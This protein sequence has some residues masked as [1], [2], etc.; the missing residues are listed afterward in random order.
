M[1]P[2]GFCQ[3]ICTYHDRAPL[4]QTRREEVCEHRSLQR[5]KRAVNG[6]PSRGGGCNVGGAAAH[7]AGGK[8]F[9]HSKRM[10]SL[11]LH[12][13]PL[14]PLWLPIY[15]F[16]PFTSFGATSGA[17]TGKGKEAREGRS[18]HQGCQHR[19]IVCYRQSNGEGVLCN[20]ERT[21][22]RRSDQHQG[23][24]QT[25]MQAAQYWLTTVLCQVHFDSRVQQLLLSSALGRM[26][27]C[28]AQRLVYLQV[29]CFTKIAD[30]GC[31]DHPVHVI[32]LVPI[33]KSS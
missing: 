14:A 6:L 11:S 29:I 15:P 20:P 23:T 31:G 5:R 9:K 26:A 17:A 3:S 21:G 7:R 1:G 16:L 12:A 18:G 27:N 33:K 30:Q 10:L 25:A 28:L 4:F 19:S 24:R 32:N 2:N 13:L 22:S 8:L